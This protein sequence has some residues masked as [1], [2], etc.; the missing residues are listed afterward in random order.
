MAEQEH[1]FFLNSLMVPILI[2]SQTEEIH[3]GLEA[4]LLVKA[5]GTGELF[6]NF[7]PEILT[8]YRE[9]EC[10]LQMGLQVSP[11][12]ATLFQKRDI[13]KKNFSDMKVQ[14]LYFTTFLVSCLL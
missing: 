9:T 2:S 7:D 12:A 4:S 13:Y 5:P 14:Y 10:M 6:V 11:L 3:F 8:L 1:V